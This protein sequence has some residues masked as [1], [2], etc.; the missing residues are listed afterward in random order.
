[1]RKNAPQEFSIRDR[2]AS[3]VE[4]ELDKHEGEEIAPTLKDHVAG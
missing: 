4:F 1:M 2:R 3:L